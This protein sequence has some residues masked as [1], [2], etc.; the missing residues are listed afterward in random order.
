MGASVAGGGSGG[1]RP[2]R[3]PLLRNLRKPVKLPNAGR[4]A[5]ALAPVGRRSP[6]WDMTT[7][8]SPAG[9]CTHGYF[10][11][12]NVGQSLKRTP[13]ISTSDSYPASPL[14]AIGVSVVL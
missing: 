10:D 12:V 8:I 2:F 5:A 9:T 4:Y 11:T 3:P 14:K 13:G 1:W 6:S 7:P